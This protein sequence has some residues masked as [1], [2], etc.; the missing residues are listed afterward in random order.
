MNPISS[1]VTAFPRLSGDGFCSPLG[2]AT[3]ASRPPGNTHTAWPGLA[4]RQLWQLWRFTLQG[5]GSKVCLPL[6]PTHRNLSHRTARLLR[7]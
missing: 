7:G 1:C 2:S 6:H 4:C 5:T 3:T